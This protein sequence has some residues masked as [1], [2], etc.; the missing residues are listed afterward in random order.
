[1]DNFVKI[2]AKPAKWIGIGLLFAATLFTTI[3]IAS[4]FGNS[5]MSVLGILLT[6]VFNLAFLGAIPMLLLFGKQRFVPYAL[7]A[8]SSYWIVNCIYQFM[9]DASSITSN[10]GALTTAVYVFEFLAALAM[11]A[12]VVLAALY[13]VNGKK[14]WAQLS[15]GVMACNLLFFVLIWVM[16]IALF[17]KVDA[18]WPAYF[19][20]FGFDLFLPAGLVFVWI[21]YLAGKVEIEEVREPAEEAEAAETETIVEEA[22]EGKIATDEE[23][24]S[25]EQNEAEANADAAETS[26]AQ[27]KQ[28]TEEDKTTETTEE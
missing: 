18:G 12:T 27:T 15:M 11:I 21:D 14:K 3:V 22:V 24:N 7:C 23:Q 2:L 28:A 13:I 8:V 4:G 5:F 17:A 19:Q 1:M 10:T 25:I 20:T 6:M 9:G 26:D 16:S